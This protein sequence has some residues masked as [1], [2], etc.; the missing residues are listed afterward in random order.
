MSGSSS[1]YGKLWSRSI[2]R[3]PHLLWDLLD[4]PFQ[5]FPS[6][7]C[8]YPGLNATQV[9]P[10]LQDSGRGVIIG[11]DIG[12]EALCT[13]YE[14]LEKLPNTGIELVA[15]AAT[16]AVAVRANRAVRGSIPTSKFGAVSRICF[17]SATSYWKQ[18]P[19]F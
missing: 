15:A 13:E 1:I 19:S 17:E 10:L 9:Y 18:P 6:G 3:G 7:T 12:G 11:T 14:E 2:L 8:G 4:K 5:H 16:A